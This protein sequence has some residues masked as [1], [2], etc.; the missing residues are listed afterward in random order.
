[1]VEEPSG[2]VVSWRFTDYVAEAIPSAAHQNDGHIAARVD[3]QSMVRIVRCL[4]TVWIIEVARRPW[5]F[6][7]RQRW[8]DRRTMRAER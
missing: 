3:F 6:D 2:L 8:D 5:S 7:G 4:G 1:M